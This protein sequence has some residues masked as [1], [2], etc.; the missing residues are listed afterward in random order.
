MKK[1]L[2][3]PNF[4]FH[5][6]KTMVQ[7]SEAVS[8]VAGTSRYVYY[9]EIIKIY[10]GTWYLVRVKINI[11]IYIYDDPQPDLICF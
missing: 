9:E 5:L 11:P 1:E 6:S 4:V 10:Q 8:L 2:T 7:T 3:V